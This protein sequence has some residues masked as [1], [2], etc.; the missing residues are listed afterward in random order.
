M[1]LGKYGKPPNPRIEALML[2]LGLS[3]IDGSPLRILCLGAHCDDIE[4]GCGGS[5][6]RLIE[7]NPSTEILWVVFSSSPIRKPEAQVAAEAFLKGAAKSEIRI[8]DFRDG[9]LPYSGSAVKDCFEALKPHF[10]PDLILTHY[11]HDLHQDHRLVSDLTW[12]T[13]RNHFILE[14]EIPKYDG[15][16]GIP[17]FFIPITEAQAANKIKTLLESYPTQ[18]DRQW[19]MEDTFY[20]LLRLRGMESN[21]PSRY[22]EAF[23]SRKAVL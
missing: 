13:Y 14:Y 19:F 17:N 22:A 10:N 12:N 8:L 11:R 21:A 15:D 3:K 4:I 20:A 18:K 16:M 6:L 5:I 7:E 1:P 9:Y 2:P 23:H